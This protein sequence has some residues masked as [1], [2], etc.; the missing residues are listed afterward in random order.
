MKNLKHFHIVEEKRKS[1]MK[2]K[3]LPAD[4]NLNDTVENRF[5][6]SITK[7]K[8]EK[9]SESYSPVRSVNNLS[10]T[11]KMI[12]HFRDSLKNEMEYPE[13]PDKIPDYIDRLKSTQALSTRCLL[14]AV[15]KQL[16]VEGNQEIIRDRDCPMP[17]NLR[18]KP[19][20]KSL[21]LKLIKGGSLACTYT[22][23]LIKACKT[24]SKFHSRAGSIDNDQLN[25][26]QNDHFD[27]PS[28]STR[29]ELTTA[30]R[31]QRLEDRI[32]SSSISKAKSLKAFNFDYKLNHPDPS[33]KKEKVFLTSIRASTYRNSMAS[34]S[35]SN[36]N[37]PVKSKSTSLTRRGSD[38]CQINEVLEKCEGLEKNTR[39][40]KRDVKIMGKKFENDLGTLNERLTDKEPK[41]KKSYIKN[42][43]NDFKHEKKAFIYGRNFQGRYIDGFVKFNQG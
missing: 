36:S 17:D 39:N 20:I 33:P 31:R 10:K 30:K 5:K 1:F 23:T 29:Q 16:L 40:D 28:F 25:L 4:A 13:D 8:E 42:I 41:F 35:I 26:N 2:T 15:K 27:N 21:N 12:E 11:G 24:I 19:E 43:I 18:E 22:G 9:P 37:S 14:E 32:R 38:I 3:K 6:I 7:P 34:T